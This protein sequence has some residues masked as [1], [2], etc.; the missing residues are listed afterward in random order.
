[1]NRCRRQTCQP[2]VAESPGLDPISAE[3]L[4]THFRGNLA[5]VE[6]L[7]DD[8]VVDAYSLRQTWFYRYN[9]E[10]WERLEPDQWLWGPKQ[11][12]QTEHFQFIY[13]ELDQEAVDLLAADAERLYA[14]VL[15][16]LGKQDA[17]DAKTFTIEI[18]PEPFPANT[19]QPE[20]IRLASPRLQPL[21]PSLT[22]RDALAWD[23]A[24]T[25]SY[26]LLRETPLMAGVTSLNTRF[27]LHC[28]LP[29]AIAQR[30]API[31][32]RNEYDR[33]QYL[34]SLVDWAGWSGAD[35]SDM[36]RWASTGWR[37]PQ[38]ECGDL[39]RLYCRPFRLRKTGRSGAGGQPNLWL[40][41]S[42][43]ERTGDRLR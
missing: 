12:M 25:I 13:H 28:M 9:N 15:V 34:R 26:Q 18:V 42:N 10:T 41:T 36:G 2:S 30:W 5:T 33:Q 38:Y 27:M 1:M 29:P 32:P 6:V 22:D 7:V 24:Y 37:K 16:G 20:R 23:F 4:S 35:M 43:R 11:V 39:W 31:E 40:A 17:G 3:V 8:P 21:H 14:D 19:T